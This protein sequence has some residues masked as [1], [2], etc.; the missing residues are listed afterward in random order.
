MIWDSFKRSATAQPGKETFAQRVYEAA[1][2]TRADARARRLLAPFKI[3]G[4]GL[5]LGT[6]GLAL[7]LGVTAAGIAGTAAGIGIGG[8][9][10]GIGGMTGLTGGGA[11][12]AAKAG[13]IGLGGARGVY[14][15]AAGV[16][17]VAR[18][19]LTGGVRGTSRNWVDAW[20]PFIK[21]PFHDQ[22]SEGSH[23]NI[24]TRKT[25]GTVTEKGVGF[26]KYG[27]NPRI[28]RRFVA[29]SAIAST[30]AG[31]AGELIEAHSPA[32][33]IYY[34]GVNIRHTNDWGADG[35]YAQGMLGRNT[36][37]R[38]QLAGLLMYL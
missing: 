10:G 13:A 2:D 18:T 26:A 34:D 21:H 17:S 33:S 22:W 30:A 32:P 29:A 14:H 16:E 19:L 11:T 15:M 8:I 36:F 23:S 9:L 7:G 20:F 28:V 24:K 6:L 3:L 35:S 31:I 4:A 38:N 1:R 5:G 12:F 25:T 27:P 37:N